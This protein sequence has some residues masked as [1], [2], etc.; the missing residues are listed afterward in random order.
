MRDVLETLFQTKC[1]EKLCATARL[2][3]DDLNILDISL[4]HDFAAFRATRVSN[5]YACSQQFD[6][7]IAASIG[8]LH[9]GT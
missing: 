1:S 7:T 5:N 6:K 2:G 4:S 8:G 9:Q 3:S